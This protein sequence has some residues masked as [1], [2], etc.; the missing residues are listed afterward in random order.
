MKVVNLEES[1][2]DFTEFEYLVFSIRFEKLKTCEF[3]QNPTIEKR[4]HNPLDC[5]VGFL[6][7]H[8]VGQKPSAYSPRT[9]RSYKQRIIEEV[10][11]INMIRTAAGMKI[12][13]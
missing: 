8:I 5:L 3:C 1:E 13:K 10:D 2:F 11:R 12:F 4:K 6:H 9:N 7:I